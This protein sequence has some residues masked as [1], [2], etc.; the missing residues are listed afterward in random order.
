MLVTLK[1]RGGHF[2][3][4]GEVEWF[5]VDDQ[6]R[7]TTLLAKV[8]PILQIEMTLLS[9]KRR[10]NAFEDALMS[11]LARGVTELQ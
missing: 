8:D 2:T 6:Q 7:P 1:S 3:D 9:G 5:L 4:S 11:I 10:M